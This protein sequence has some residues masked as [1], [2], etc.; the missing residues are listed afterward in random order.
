MST[1]FFGKSEV[2]HTSVIGSVVCLLH[3]AC[4][5]NFRSG[6]IRSEPVILTQIKDMTKWSLKYTF[7]G[8]V[9]GKIRVREF[10]FQ[11]CCAWSEKLSGNHGS[12]PQGP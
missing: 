1:V 3:V 11:L 10:S 6:T 4:N 5:N 7:R 12:L 2:F 9:P 8:E